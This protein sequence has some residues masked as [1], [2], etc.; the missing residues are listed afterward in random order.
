M[1]II[2]AASCALPCVAY[3]IDGVID[4]VV[5]GKTGLLVRKGDAWDFRN[6]IEVLYRNPRLR[7]KLGISAQ[8]RTREN[9]SSKLITEAWLDFYHDMTSDNINKKWNSEK[10]DFV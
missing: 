3:K 5:D 7:L 6:K 2:E 8:K 4:A 1:V 10:N 9:F